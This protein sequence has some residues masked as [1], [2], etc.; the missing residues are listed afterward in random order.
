MVRKSLR[1]LDRLDKKESSRN[2]IQ[3]T[4]INKLLLGDIL[5]TDQ[6]K[7]LRRFSFCFSQELRF[8]EWLITAQ[9]HVNAICIN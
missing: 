7:D 8:L 2:L 6:I 1:G 3:K 9:R 5:E 4:Q